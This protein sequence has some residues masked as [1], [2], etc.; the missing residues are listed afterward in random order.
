MLDRL[1]MPR[2][3]M[4]FEDYVDILRRNIRWIIGPV[5]AGLIVSTVIAFSMQDTFVS[6]ALIRIVPQQI[7]ESLVQNASAQD[8]SDR[9][10]GMAQSILSRTTLTALI[11]TYGLYKPELKSEPLQDVIEKMKQDISIRTQG[12]ITNVSGKGSPAMELAFQYRDRFLA[13]KVCSELV[14]RFMNASTQ[15]TLDSQVNGN[16]FIKDEY[17]RTKQQL[18]GLEQKLA[19]Y[20]ARHAGSLPE[21]MTTNFQEMSAVEQR[22]NALSD[23]ASR[24]SERR[25]MLETSLRITKDR[26]AGL[27]AIP[28]V[29]AARTEHASELD[30]QITDLESTIA[31]LKDRYTADYPDLQA[32][33]DR[34]VVLKRQRDE[35]AK[36]APK[37]DAPAAET[38]A[39][40]RERMDIQA[41]VEAIESQ[42]KIT[43]VQDQQ[44]GREIQTANSQLRSLQARVEGSPS[45]EKEYTDLLRERDLARQKY[46]DLDGKMNKSNQSMDLERR[47]Q[48]ETLELLDAASLPVE[49]TAPKRATII[50]IGAVVGLL[51][52]VVIVGIRE[53]KDTSLKNLKDARL[54]TQLSILG[55]IPLLENDVVVQ[56]R[57]QVMLIGWATATVVG[58]AIIAGSVLHYYLNRA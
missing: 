21:Q 8:I 36:A 6:R 49:P 55:S 23:A 5:F 50:P 40:A 32:A 27:K 16:Q 3:A 31:S 45:G 14:S 39:L 24:N 43:N 28:Q 13:N 54:Y 1:A 4:D 58:L 51:L 9:I 46:I 20:R 47:K 37:T 42:I 56:R 7:S 53:V 41:Q 57:K 48:G 44:V 52:G 15:E 35:A 33:Q 25:M 18:D 17:D 29:S 12:S 26:L 2:R 10:N 34:L 22:L 11:N 19:D 38:P 30:R